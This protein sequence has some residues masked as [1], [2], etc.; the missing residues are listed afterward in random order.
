MQQPHPIISCADYL[1]HTEAVPLCTLPLCTQL[2][3]ITVSSVALAA[4]T[5]THD[6]HVIPTNLLSIIINLAAPESRLYVYTTPQVLSLLVALLA[7][8]SAVSLPYLLH[9]ICTT[10][11]Y[12]LP[13]CLNL[14]VRNTL[15]EQL[16][17][18]TNSTC[19][20]NLYHTAYPLFY[21]AAKINCRTH[22]QLLLQS[23]LQYYW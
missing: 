6:V 5:S 8:P 11:L 14:S 7:L 4:T 2:V 21:I 1:M 18:C 12:Y 16:P 22:L 9:V 10:L 19:D 23:H 3:Y 15:E 20:C 17:L 13:L